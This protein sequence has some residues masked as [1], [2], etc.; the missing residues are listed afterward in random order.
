MKRNAREYEPPRM[1]IYQFDDNDQILTASS[2][3]NPPPVTTD[4]TQPPTANYAANAL[5]EFMGGTNTT[6][7]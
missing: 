1:K 5:N 6:I 7:E 3:T 4:P 2:G